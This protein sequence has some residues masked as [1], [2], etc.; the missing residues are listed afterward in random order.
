MV[1]RTPPQVHGLW[2]TNANIKPTYAVKLSI[3]RKEA[4]N[5]SF[6]Y[7]GTKRSADTMSST[8]GKTIALSVGK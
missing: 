4:F 2:G 8:V 6:L 5:P 1:L 3:N 7:L